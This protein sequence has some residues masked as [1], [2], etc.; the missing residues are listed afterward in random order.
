MKWI[1]CF[2]ICATVV[3]AQP[4][5]LPNNR[6]ITSDDNNKPVAVQYYWDEGSSTFKPMGANSVIFTRMD[7]QYATD[8]S[9][10]AT[11]TFTLASGFRDAGVVV[12]NHATAAMKIWFDLG[13]TATGA[14]YDTF[15]VDAGT[16]VFFP[17]NADTLYA[18]ESASAPELEIQQGKVD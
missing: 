18:R 12:V 16:S 13:S 6:L 5:R 7:G 10:S 14:A 9:T 17:V 1:L 11:S 4:T 8:V 2:L 15:W 3:L